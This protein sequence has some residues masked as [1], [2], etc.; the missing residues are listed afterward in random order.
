MSDAQQLRRRAGVGLI[1]I[2]ALVLAILGGGTPVA[3]AELN[4]DSLTDKASEIAD[5]IGDIILGDDDSGSSSDESSNV[6]EPDSHSITDKAKDVAE[7]VKSFIENIGAAPGNVADVVR[8]CGFVWCR[9]A[10]R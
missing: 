7:G 3:T 5:F 9:M 4:L 1:A 8:R 6:E 2:L 10:H